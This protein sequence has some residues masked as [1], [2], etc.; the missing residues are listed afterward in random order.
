MRMPQ[1]DSGTRLEQ[2]RNP[3]RVPALHGNRWYA[4]LLAG[5]VL[6]SNGCLLAA[7]AGVV[8]SAAAVGASVDTAR[9]GAVA[10]RF[11]P[12]RSLELKYP[13]RDS[14]VHMTAQRVAGRVARI[15]ADTVWVTISEVRNAA[16]TH[17]FPRVGAPTAAILR[18]GAEVS[19]LASR[20][21]TA[22]WAYAGF[23]IG[24]A[25]A[26]GTLVVICWLNPCFA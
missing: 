2:C 5:T 25:L 16:G 11:D 14:T 4:F 21:R 8:G 1:Y 20:P 17:R 12:A 22:E 23:F 3:W 26:L 7:T 19:V 13:G 18:E 9:G 24:T 6:A 15:A 10:V